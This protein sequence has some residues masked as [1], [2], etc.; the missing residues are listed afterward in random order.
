M[1]LVR[2]L[3]WLARR[4]GLLTLAYHRVGAWENQPFDDELFSAT[5]DEFETQIRYLRDDFE[6]L[7]ID[8]LLQAIQGDRLD[9][10]RPSA[11]I[12]F[13]D[14]Y[15][16]NCEVAFPI[17]RWFG[18]PA[19][20]FVAAGYIDQPRLAWWDRVAYIVKSTSKDALTLDCPAPVSINLIETGRSRAI[21]QILRIYMRTPQMNQPR[22]FSRLEAQAEV[23]VDA[24]AL[25]RDLFMSW[26]QIRE[27]KRGGMEIGA[28]TYDHP[29]LS[30]LSEEAQSRELWRSKQRLE[31][32]TGR[33][34]RVMAYP[35]G[36]HDCFT[37]V[38]QRVARNAGYR[39]A[40]SY[41]GGFNRRGRV[42]AFDLKRISVERHHS[43]PMFRWRASM[44]DL[45]G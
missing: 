6:L 3:G 13:D 1:G 38:T 41:Y 26:D 20:F 10:Q 33:P 4:K 40:F 7:S 28:H 5:A 2:L 30:R 34:I 24:E 23:T 15:R 19:V 31:S 43:F 9:L 25:G 39:A 18:V 8:S 35:V 12:T 29:V 16:D 42:D 14:G 45:F 17:L 22:F 21:Q 32:E 44:S 11:L 37:A 27:L 36:K